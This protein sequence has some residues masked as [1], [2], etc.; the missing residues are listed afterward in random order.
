ME[1]DD[2]MHIKLSPFEYS[3]NVILNEIINTHKRH[4]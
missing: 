1:V 2:R 4:R 3:N